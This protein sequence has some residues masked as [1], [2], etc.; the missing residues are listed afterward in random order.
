[1]PV[2]VGS[3]GWRWLSTE[4]AG[5]GEKR[6]WLTLSNAQ[7]TP[8]TRLNC[9]DESEQICQQRSR[10]ASCQRCERT[11]RQSWRCPSVMAARWVG[12]NSGPV[13]RRLWTKV[14]QFN[15]A[16]AG[17]IAVCKVVF[18]LTTSCCSPEILPSSIA[19][20]PIFMF[21][22]FGSHFFF[23]GGGNF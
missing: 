2:A 20:K 8:P 22:G 11:R 13:F 17:V 7:Y 23:G 19:K 1:M 4:S 5:V 10:V 18:R 3:F 9:L 6:L 14:R 16:C 12:R 15:Y 21:L